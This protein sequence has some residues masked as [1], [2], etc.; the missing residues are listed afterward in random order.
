MEPGAAGGAGRVLRR[1][2]GARAPRGARRRRLSKRTWLIILNTASIVGGIAIWWALALSGLQLPT[3]P[4]V[5]QKAIQMW[6]AGI[7]QED[8]LASLARV[9]SGFLL[10]TAVAGS[11]DPDRW[12]VSGVVLGQN[13]LYLLISM[14]MGL[15]FGAVARSSAP[16]IVAFF[17]LPIGFALVGEIHALHG[18]WDWLDT[19]RTFDPLTGNDALSAK[20]WARLGVSLLPWLALPFGLGMWRLLRGEVRS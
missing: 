7:L 14:L 2:G 10:G 6:N 19:T 13:V 8:V 9:L 18:T 11:D 15:A 17:V 4:Q 12:N 20:E 1:Y 16:A 5:V 3:P